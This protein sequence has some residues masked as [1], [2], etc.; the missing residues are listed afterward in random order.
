MGCE[1]F[2]IEKSDIALGVVKDTT[3]PSED[4]NVLEIT[5][6]TKSRGGLFVNAIASRDVRFIDDSRYVF[7]GYFKKVEGSNPEQIDVNLTLVENYVE[8]Y[9]EIIWTLNPYAPQYEWVWTRVEGFKPIKLFELPDDSNW[10][11]FQLI[12]EYKSSPKSRRIRRIQVDDQVVDLDLEMGTVKKEWR[13]SFGVLLET[14]N[15]YTNCDAEI[16]FVGKSRWDKVAVK[17][18]PLSP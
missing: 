3:S 9:A 8:H 17:V 1:N 16:M 4:K 11:Y 14:H 2:P 12:T 7:C 5:A 6:N 15:M 18:E 13:F 10:H